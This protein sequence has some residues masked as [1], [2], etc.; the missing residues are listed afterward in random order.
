MILARQYAWFGFFHPGDRLTGELSVVA[1]MLRF[2]A[3]LVILYG[4]WNR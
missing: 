3:A 1:H 2:A 4:F